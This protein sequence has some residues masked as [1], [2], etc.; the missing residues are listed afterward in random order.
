MRRRWWCSRPSVPEGG[1]AGFLAHAPV[2]LEPSLPPLPNIHDNCAMIRME[3][4]WGSESES[5]S[6]KLG[7]IPCTSHDVIWLRVVPRPSA[8]LAPRPTSSCTSSLW[9]SESEPARR[10]N[11]IDLVKQIHDDLLPFVPGIPKIDVEVPQ[12]DQLARGRLIIVHSQHHSCATPTAKKPKKRLK[13][14]SSAPV[15]SLIARADLHNPTAHVGMG[16]ERACWLS[17]NIVVSVAF[18]PP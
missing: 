13:K 11:S 15:Q 10:I 7:H 16:G 4:P 18:G 3:K 14:I 1:I 9:H 5:H 12:N 2:A 17:S 6:L 8:L